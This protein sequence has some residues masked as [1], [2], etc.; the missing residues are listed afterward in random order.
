[1]IVHYAGL[2][3]VQ[4][5]LPADTGISRQ[6]EGHSFGDHFASASVSVTP[7]SVMQAS[8]VLNTRYIRSKVMHYCCNH[9]LKWFFQKLLE[10]T[11]P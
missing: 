8:I 11:L 3:D 1:M 6:T 2:L 7:S 5:I 10:K 4:N 9:M